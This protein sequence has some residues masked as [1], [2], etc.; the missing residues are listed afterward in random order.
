MSSEER[1]VALPRLYGA[2]AYA[3]PPKPVGLVPARPI[4]PDDLPLEIEMTPD[5]RALIAAGGGNPFGP[6]CGA[7][8]GRS[9]VDGNVDG[10]VD[11]PR[12]SSRFFGRS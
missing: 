8:I 10:S 7:E 2:S 3:R 9:P 6:A 5:E 12:F 11:R 1:H 4:D